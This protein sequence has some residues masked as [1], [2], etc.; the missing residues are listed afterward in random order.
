MERDGCPPD[1]CTYNV[2]VRGF[3][4]NNG[5]SRAEQLFQEMFDRGFYADAQTRTLVADLLCKDDNLGL[6]RLL[7]ES[8]CCQGEKVM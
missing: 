3:L 5:A 1:D 8:E 7:G 4:W 6:K 2:I